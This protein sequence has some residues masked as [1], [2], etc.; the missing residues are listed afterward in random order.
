MSRKVLTA[1]AGLVAVTCVLVWVSQ[2]QGSS[3]LGWSAESRAQA[4]LQIRQKLDSQ[5]QTLALSISSSPPAAVPPP[6]KHTKLR[7]L[8]REA[9]IRRVVDKATKQ[10]NIMVLSGKGKDPSVSIQDIIKSERNLM[11]TKKKHQQAVR[12]AIIAHQKLTA[13]QLEAARRLWLKQNGLKQVFDAHSPVDLVVKPGHK[14]TPEQ[15][16]AAHDL[17]ERM[18]DDNRQVKAAVEKVVEDA[19]KETEGPSVHAEP[20]V[21]NRA[22]KDWAYLMGLK[23]N[24]LAT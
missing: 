15:M 19:K 1:A 2:T 20:L 13:K 3:V 16:M 9:A 8:Q 11:I 24:E 6:I 7:F 14:P 12:S 21:V 22:D 4:E 18:L 10:A 23:N 17:Q 5:A